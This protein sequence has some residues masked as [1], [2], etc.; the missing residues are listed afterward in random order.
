[1]TRHAKNSTASAVYSYHEKK[2]DSHNGIKKIRLGKDSVKNFDACSLTL[3]PC[4]NPVITKDG[5]LYDKEAILQYIVTKRKELSQGLSEYNNQKQ[6]KMEEDL[7][8]SRKNSERN[9]QK[10]IETNKILAKSKQTIDESGLPSVNRL[11]SNNHDKDFHIII[12]DISKPKTKV[13]CPITGTVLKAKDLINV[14]FTKDLTSSSSSMSNENA[15]ICAIT[16][17]ALNNSTSCAVIKTTG[18]VVTMEC[19]DKIIRKDWIHPLTNEKLQET[20]IVP[21]QRGG[22]GFAQTNTIA[23]K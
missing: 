1:M 8:L 12:P 14:K 13:V 21:L 18:D 2:K 19:I 10:F 16:Q 23:K 15:Y 3:Q 4:K 22:T 11:S 17:D 7:E 6:S 9:V 20:D 5:V